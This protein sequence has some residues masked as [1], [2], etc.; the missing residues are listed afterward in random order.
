ML[1]TTVA[2]RAQLVSGQ[3]FSGAMAPLAMAG[4]GTGIDSPDSSQ[5]AEGVR[6]IN[7]GRW[8]DATAIFAN[9]VKQQGSHADG[10]L[11]WKAYA[12]NKQGQSKSA[13]DTCAGLHRDYPNSH[14]KDECGALE[15]EI[16]TKAGQ[17]VQPKAMDSDDLKLLALNSLL[18]TDETR[19]LAQIQEILNSDFSPRLKQGAMFLLSQYHT[20]AT[21]AQ[22][23][24]ISYAEG[25]VRISRGQEAEKTA[26]ATWE[27]AAA[28]I[29]LETGFSLATG[30]GRAEIEFEN[31][32][33]LY[34]GENSVLTFNDLHTTGGVPF[35]ELALLSGTVSL[36]VHPFTAGEVF[37]LRTPTDDL[38]VIYPHKFTARVGAY[39]D[40]T[41][42]TPR[43]Q[44]ELHLPMLSQGN[45]VATGQTIALRE[46]KAI[47]VPGTVDP[48]A[49]AEWDKWVA[50]RV[51]ERSAAMTR[52]MKASGLPAPIPGMAEMEGEGTFFDCAP[53]GTCWEPN[54]PNE[55][56]QAGNMQTEPRPSAGVDSPRSAKAASAGSPTAIRTIQFDEFFP[57]IPAG[58]RYR[59]MRDSVTGKERVVDTLL[60]AYGSRLPYDW[61]VCHAG[62]WI[63][64]NHRY[65][66]VAGH[67]RHHLEP[68]RWIKSGHRVAFVPIHPYDVKGRPPLNRKEEVFA[69]DNKHGLAIERV[70]FES[71][72]PIVALAEP[73]KEFRGTH[74]PP[75]SRAEE[76]RL[77]AHQLKDA[78]GGKT[79]L[80][81]AAG[82]PLKFDSKLQSFTMT[83][84][85]MQGNK[86]ATVSVPITNHGGN[87]QSRGG[88]YTGGGG[89]S[90]GGS[91]GSGNYSGGARAGGGGSSSGGSHSSGSSGGSSSGGSHSSGSSSVSTSSGS[92]VST[93]SVSSGGSSSST[94]S[95]SHH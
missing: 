2:S 24:R 49:F 86:S 42:I 91:R 94:S 32:S 68:V 53:Y 25:D 95:G 77:A 14:W 82:I 75:L 64:R 48:T 92:S 40:A 36:D 88:S 60:E 30:A 9:V 72:R 31:A 39:L 70:K 10:A 38:S 87:L 50:G 43:G 6:A 57:C 55:R 1:C 85:V 54:A 46:G 56:E 7:Q 61:A 11:Y 67:K 28:G 84:Q 69:I 78:L 23:V 5:Y 51:A 16:R 62:S 59:E 12:E 74:L 58:L 33:T 13:L 37:I 4:D 22:I 76:P 17:P 66:W 3:S 93:S 65:V 34:L 80:A 63:R 73:P 52:V 47:E 79:A 45:I 18:Q 27:K 26:G 44:G 20:D 8:A 41:T 83:R 29:P 35:T 81:A 89:F 21:Y 71:D 90:G 19:G 15:I